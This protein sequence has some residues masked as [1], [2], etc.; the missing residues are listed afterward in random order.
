[1][2]YKV[3]AISSPGSRARGEVLSYV[4]TNQPD[5]WDSYEK[6]WPW[7]AEFPLGIGNCNEDQRRRAN[8]Y[9][10]YMNRV[11]PQQPPIGA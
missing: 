6:K 2:S 11:T 4:V 8:E 9:R 3:L 5:N 10:D 1:M 7:V